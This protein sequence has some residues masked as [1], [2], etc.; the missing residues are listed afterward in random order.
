[1]ATYTEH[2]DTV[3]EGDTLVCTNLDIETT[4]SMSSLTTTGAA[5]FNVANFVGNGLGQ[6]TFTTTS[7][8]L[9]VGGPWVDLPITL[10]PSIERSVSSTTSTVIPVFPG[11][12][13]MDIGGRIESPV[14]TPTT[15]F[16]EIG[17]SINGADPVRPVAAAPVNNVE[18]ASCFSFSYQTVPFGGVITFK[19]RCIGTVTGIP[20]TMNIEIPFGT[21][22]LALFGLF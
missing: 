12:Y 17:V 11:F 5:F 18:S 22:A 2:D 13:G 6:Y 15:P 8:T 7:L 10:T 19:A 4:A 21:Y 14:P 9:T 20:T 1:M 3:A 16:F